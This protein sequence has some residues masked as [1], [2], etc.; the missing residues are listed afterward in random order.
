MTERD[1]AILAAILAARA[2][3]LRLARREQQD[4]QRQDVHRLH[5]AMGA[6]TIALLL[7]EDRWAV[8][9]LLRVVWWA[10][11]VAGRGG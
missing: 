11:R 6:L 10:G 3:E 9:V 1:R 4:G 5:A 2:D 7:A 8:V